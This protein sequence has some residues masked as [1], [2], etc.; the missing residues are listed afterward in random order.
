MAVVGSAG[1]QRGADLRTPAIGAKPK[2]EDPSEQ[3][4]ATRARRTV[5]NDNIKADI[6]SRWSDICK[7]LKA[8]KVRDRLCLRVAWAWEHD[9]Q[10]P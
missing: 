5:V 6:E 4:M 1:E 8:A 10:R 2:E 3:R 9:S 7:T